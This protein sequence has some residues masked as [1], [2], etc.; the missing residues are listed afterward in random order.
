MAI[1]VKSLRSNQQENQIM[2]QKITHRKTEPIG[3]YNYAILHSRGLDNVFNTM[4][5]DSAFFAR[6]ADFE[7]IVQSL[8]NYGEALT[9]RFTILLAKYDWSGITKAHWT[10]AR[11]LSDQEYEQI[12]SAQSLYELNSEMTTLRP[13]KPL[14]WKSELEITDTLPRILQA[15]FDN[16]A[17]PSDEGS[18]HQ[19][20]RA[21]YVSEQKP[22]TVKL[23]N[24]Q[25]TES[26]WRIAK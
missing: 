24:F 9:H 12:H 15:M 7:R 1:K 23:A 22:M 3:Y 5:Y 11:L 14:K 4:R 25:M 8:Q 20:E 18:A 13:T 19:I 17:F 21:F 26:N 6:R 10:P 2:D 16:Q